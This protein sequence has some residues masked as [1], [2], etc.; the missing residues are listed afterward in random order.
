MDQGWTFETLLV[1]MGARFEETQRAIQTADEEREKSAQ[2][3]A[4][5]L[6]IQIDAGDHALLLHIENQKDALE[7]LRLYQQQE[8]TASE[9][10]ITKA[11]NANE[12][13]F[14]GVNAFR[15]Q[16]GIQSKGFLPRELFDQAMDDYRQRLDTIANGISANTNRITELEAR[17]AAGKDTKAD[18]KSTIAI[19]AASVTGAIAILVS[20]FTR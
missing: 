8:N 12:K 7:A 10:A 3:L 20:V 15:E 17:T 16:L 19:L 18:L 9:K 13:R 2:A 6:K 14:E 5:A 1:Y 11:E 4:T